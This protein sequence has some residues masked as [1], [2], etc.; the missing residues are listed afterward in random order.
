MLLFA[1][2]IRTVSRH[3]RTVSWQLF[4]GCLLAHCLLSWALMSWAGEEKLTTLVVWL[5]YYMVTATTV[6][7][8]DF[9]PQSDAGRL[10]AVLVVLPGGVSLFAVMVGKV[11]TQ[12]ADFWRRRA[13]GKLDFTQLQGHTI[14]VGWHGEA[15][16]RMVELLLQDVTTD[17]EGI[18][19]A[20]IQDMDNPLP[21]K[22][23]FVRGES[24]H[25]GTLLHRAGLNG[26]ARVLVY[27]HNDEEN[28]ATALSILRDRPQA[29]VVC[30]FDDSA[31]A[32]LL[33][34]LYPAAETTSTLA[35]EMLVR[36]AQDPGTSAVTNELLTPGQGPT[37]YALTLPADFPP[38]P[39]G[40]LFVCL[41]ERHDA[42]ALGLS[43][44]RVGV[45]LKLNPAASEIVSPLHTLYYMAHQRL[46]ATAVR[47]CV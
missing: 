11:T 36:A 46:D 31:M 40:K 22:L 17:D 37:Q 28:L 13:M 14:L 29:H 7:Y 18:V 16:E 12:L 38:T 21:D 9:S 44:D 1:T 19:L 27:G 47:N 42:T 32:L 35:V 25:S 33:K 26:A 24:F 34:Q 2:L 3:L 45:A 15:S 30:H 43:A 5:Y 20:V 4:A 10:V 6:G 23:R 8:G 39:F 41:K